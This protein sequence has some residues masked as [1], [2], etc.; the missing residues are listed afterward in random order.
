M[1]ILILAAGTRNKI[2]QYFK[3]TIKSAGTVSSIINSGTTNIMWSALSGDGWDGAWKAGL[4]GLATGYWESQQYILDNW[5]IERRFEPEMTEEKRAE[6]IK[7]WEK[8]VSRVMGW[9]K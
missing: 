2:V 3:R 5:Q 8:A 1:N 6:L 7:G 9:A 4:A